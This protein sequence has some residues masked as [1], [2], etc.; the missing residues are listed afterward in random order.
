MS[1]FIHL[2][3]YSDYSLGKSA[4]K[5]D[6][7]V[8][9]CY[10][11]ALPA[12]GLSDIS[13]LF[14][15]LEFSLKCADHGIQSI[16]S[17]IITVDVSA[18]ITNTKATEHIYQE[19]LLIAK[20]EKGYRNLLKL[21][22]SLYLENYAQ[23]QPLH[24]HIKQLIQLSEGLIVLYGGGISK[25][26]EA[27]SLTENRVSLITS[28]IH[29]LYEIFNINF[30]IELIRYKD[31]K[32]D[33]AI[34]S[35]LLELAWHNDIP[36]VATN[37]VAYM[38]QEAYQAHDALLCIA[39]NAY[40]MQEDRIKSHPEH[41]FK[42]ADEMRELFSDLP[43]AID[44]TVLIAQKCS[45]MPQRGASMLP[46]FCE[47]IE[48][49]EKLLKQKA[50]VGLKARLS[51]II[52]EAHQQYHARLDF[53][54]SVIQNMRFAGYFL[55]VADFVEWAKNEQ[56][57][58]GPGR[59]SGA[60][61][62]V[63]WALN[64]TDVDPL[65][66]G[67]IFERFLNPDRISI[68]DF[69]IDICQ[70]HRDRVIDYVRH[71]YGIDKVAHIITFGTLQ[72]RGVLR[73]IGR[74][75]QMPYSLIDK[76]SKMIPQNLANPVTLQ[77]A[78]DLDP[79]L[80]HLRD[81]ESDIERLFKLSLELEGVHRHVSTHAT[82]IV[83]GDR[84]LDEV[85]ALYKDAKSSIP[86]IQYSLK[87][88]DAAGL[89]KFDFLGLKTLTVI[90]DTCS[91]IQKHGNYIEASRIPLDDSKTYNMLM[92]GYTVGVFQFEGAGIREALKELQPDCIED[93]IALGAL[94]RPGPM[95]N[96]PHY[97][98]R[99]H[100]LE[101][102]EE[103]HPKITDLLKET[104]GIIIYQ[105]QVM[106][107]AQILAGYTLAKADL[108]RYA[109]G[110]K[111]KK[112]MKRQKDIFVTG[113]IQ[114]NLTRNEAEN[115]F[116]I[117]SKFASYGFNKSHA[118][119]YGI[120]SCQTAYLKA[121]YT[122]EFLVASMNLEIHDT[123]KLSIFCNEAK[124]FEIKLLHPCI[125]TSNTLFI[126]EANSIRFGLAGIKGVGIK[127]VDAILK[128]RKE[129]G[130]F[131]DI[132][133]FI[134]RTG[135]I[136]NKKL[137]EALIKAGAFDI[138]FSNRASLLASINLL[139][140][141][142]Q[143]ELHQ[144][145]RKQINIFSII[146]SD[147]SHTKAI[148][149]SSQCSLEDISPW[150]FNTKLAAEYEAFGFYPNEHPLTPYEGKL[151]KNVT[152]QDLIHKPQLDGAHIN[153]AGV[154]TTKRVK[155]TKTQSKFAFIQISDQYGVADLSIFDE[156][157]LRGKVGDLSEVGK[158][159]SC[160]AIIKRDD[161]GMR[162]IVE[163]ICALEELVKAP[164]I[165]RKC[166]IKILS[167]DIIP[168]LKSALTIDNEGII[169]TEIIAVLSDR[170]EVSFSQESPLRIDPTKLDALQQYGILEL[171]E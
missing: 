171:I 102:V 74:V 98:R 159:I 10:K 90:A 169:C 69:D 161:A 15:A 21:V 55:I 110:K 78:I 24:I 64:I 96:I 63:A 149:N 46:K 139:L 8:E 39:N 113:A 40:V 88:A 143:M 11:N 66:F 52:K 32:Y 29:K 67:L 73:D 54:L 86:S 84:P 148:I 152:T 80:Q 131:T 62:V 49:E 111:D 53:E 57:P 3:L 133:N 91:L 125:N 156:N 19:L 112:E 77:E 153:I 126:V 7:L 26:L 117:I 144:E 83:I 76:L 1:N 157:L 37:H 75:L 146:G 114:N 68:P 47:Y 166:R 132:F 118:T 123:D 137:L 151:K 135:R 16:I 20:N 158:I 30:F 48:Q 108:L 103:I 93:L 56:I 61:S 130:K 50:A 105:E 23:N 13:N 45:F 145:T 4:I 164:Q 92:A 12:I 5:I 140:Q 17:C 35:L 87:Y 136:I 2:R 122:I 94:Y 43:E 138:L 162:I 101:E 27:N 58:V 154:I 33:K 107:M 165:V 95:D 81:T 51:T 85:V 44:N 127:A 72:A 109:M 115:V 60:G 9:Y 25:H 163:R 134:S 18:C 99:K 116:S 128:E 147:A 142:A 150:D 100:G 160:T 119:A 70:L 28:L 79:E 36:I 121:N 104:Y 124:R 65:K 155:S 141:Q 170:T 167:E 38:S 22:S 106:R 129:G 71:K 42:S 6:N 41:Y 168:L 34:E 120:I 82:G 59:G 97:I 89:V 31:L 14:G